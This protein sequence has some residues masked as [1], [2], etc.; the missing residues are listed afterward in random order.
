MNLRS[1]AFTFLPVTFKLK[2]V[3]LWVDSELF[4]YKTN[5]DISHFVSR[6]VYQ[7]DKQS[8]FQ[9]F[10][11]KNLKID[12]YVYNE[13]FWD[14]KIPKTFRDSDRQQKSILVRRY[15]GHMETKYCFLFQQ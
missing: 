11:F 2:S 7:K 6:L 10:T 8:W 4:N 9:V 3:L 14:K 1:I 15:A 13:H 12:S 5:F